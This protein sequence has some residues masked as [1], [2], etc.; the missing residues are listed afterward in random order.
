ML[1]AILKLFF[2]VT[3][4]NKLILEILGNDLVVNYFDEIIC[5][6][7]FFYLVFKNK[8]PKTYSILI[9]IFFGINIISTI[10]SNF[11]LDFNRFFLDIFLFLKPII[12]IMALSRVDRDTFQSI[13]YFFFKISRAYIFLAILLLPIHYIFEIF[14]IYDTRFGLKS[15]SFIA[16]NAGEF[17]NIV[18]I[19]GIIS[20]MG[21]IKWQNNIFITFCL[22]L[23]ISTLRYKAFVVAFAYLLFQ[24]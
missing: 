18:L 1:K 23:L 11:P 15:Y 13:F 21:K 20:T 9:I 4:L 14:S 5:I 17:L 6:I 22:I 24:N 7:L 19:T 12:F 8:I 16:H 3:I 2:I 10:Q